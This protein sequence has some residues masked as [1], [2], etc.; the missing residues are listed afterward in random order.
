MAL[1]LGLA[2]FAML[3][4]HSRD[5]VKVTFV[6]FENSRDGKTT[7]A[8]FYLT[9]QTRADFALTVVEPDGAVFGRFHPGIQK[10]GDWLGKVV[11]AGWGFDLRHHSDQTVRVPLPNDGRIGQVEVILSTIEVVE[12]GIRG[13]VFS[14]W[15]SFR[16]RNANHVEAICNQVIQCPLVRPDGTVEPPRIL[17]KTPKR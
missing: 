10:G 3:E 11:T 5:M 2:A 7:L 12:S 16:L 13:R 14:W 4:T 17:P 1:V 9:N 8:V 15:R 6:R